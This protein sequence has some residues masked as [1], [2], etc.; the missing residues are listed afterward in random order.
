MFDWVALWYS[1]NDQSLVSS[2]YFHESLKERERERERER[3][4]ECTPEDSASL[5]LPP[6]ARL[7]EEPGSGKR[8]ERPVGGARGGAR[9][10][11]RKPQ[12]A[13]QGGTFPGTLPLTPPASS[14]FLGPCRSK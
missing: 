2:L 4:G 1:R 7:G 6:E 14:V 9:E 3:R 11:E 5:H 10:T 13:W 8:L 12:E